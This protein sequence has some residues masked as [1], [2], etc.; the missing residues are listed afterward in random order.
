[1]YVFNQ[2]QNR[3]QKAFSN[4]KCSFVYSFVLA[5]YEAAVLQPSFPRVSICLRSS[6]FWFTFRLSTTV[7]CEVQILCLLKM[8]L[9]IIYYAFT[10]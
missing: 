10:L 6:S 7:V 9:I 5:N 2:M 4:K 1:M 8:K 3:L